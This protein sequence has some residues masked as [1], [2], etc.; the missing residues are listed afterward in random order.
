MA[1][2]RRA[3]R[4]FDQAPAPVSAAKARRILALLERM[5][6]LRTFDSSRN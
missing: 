1:C 6:S 4:L 2:V 3:I 5:D